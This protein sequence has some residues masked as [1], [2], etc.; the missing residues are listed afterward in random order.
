MKKGIRHVKGTDAFR[1][2]ADHRI[3]LDLSLHAQM[4]MIFLKKV[5]LFEVEGQF[6]L[7]VDLDRDLDV[8]RCHEIV[9]P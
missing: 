9:L 4:G 7:L 1:I 2:T 8:H 6:D 3:F 5:H